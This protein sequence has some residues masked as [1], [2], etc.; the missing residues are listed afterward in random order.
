MK[1]IFTIIAMIVTV[2]T[3][4]AQN[5]V[6][7]QELHLN[8]QTY[9]VKDYIFREGLNGVVQAKWTHVIENP[10]L[11]SDW[12]MIYRVPGGY[13]IKLGNIC[14]EFNEYTITSF[15]S[16]TIPESWTRDASEAEKDLL[17]CSKVSNLANYADFD[18]N[19]IT[20]GK[21]CGYVYVSDRLTRKQHVIVYGN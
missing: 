7:Y 21:E 15:E 6:N 18:V 9:D 17:K 10:Y 11:N 3:V 20:A 5:H 12:Q 2:V 1:K 19:A 16:N 13:G 4:S 8:G 14:Y